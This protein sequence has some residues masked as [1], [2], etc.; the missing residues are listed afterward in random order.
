M[1]KGIPVPHHEPTNSAPTSHEIAQRAYEIFLARGATD[2]HD[3]EDWLQA[4]SELRS[5][6]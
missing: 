6:S 1:R 3:V 5:A 2:G 4:E